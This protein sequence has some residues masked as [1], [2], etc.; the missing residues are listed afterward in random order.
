MKAI[1]TSIP[2]MMIKSTSIR[3]LTLE[4]ITV[5]LL[6]SA[7]IVVSINSIIQIE[8][9][10]A[11]WSFCVIP[12]LILSVFYSRPFS[13]NLEDKTKAI[14]ILVA[15]SL[16]VLFAVV[17][18]NALA[19]YPMIFLASISSLVLIEFKT[20]KFTLLAIGVLSIVLLGMLLNGNTEGNIFNSLMVVNL[21]ASLISTFGIVHYAIERWQMKTE[22]IND[23][24]KQQLSFVRFV[25]ESPLPLMRIDES[26]KILLMNSAAKDL[27]ANGEDNR[28]I[29]PPG[30]GESVIQAFMSNT[31]QELTTLVNG[32]TI[33]LKITPNREDKYVNLYGEDIT[34]I[35]KANEKF[36]ELNRAID[37]SADGVAVIDKDLNFDYI[38]KSFCSILGYNHP[39]ELLAKSWL[40]ILNEE[41]KEIFTDTIS[42]KLGLE[43]I[44]RGEAVCLL[45]GSG[46][47]DTYISLTKIPEGKIICYLKDNTEIKEYHNALIKAK[48]GAEAA[49]V[50]K[51]EFLSSMS[52]EIRTPLNG[53]LGMTTILE[54]T[55]LN[56]EQ[57]DYLTTIKHSGE[58]LLSIVNQVLDFSKIEAGDLE[59]EEE[60]VS[61]RKLIG[62]TMKL[63]THRASTRNNI[64]TSHIDHSVPPYVLGDYSR[65]S[66][67]LYNL[68][69][70]AIKFTD[71]GKVTIWVSAERTEIPKEIRLHFSIEDTGIGIKDEKVKELF[72]PFT[73]ADSSATREYGGTGLGLTIC[74]RLVT[75]MGGEINVKSEEG[76]GS[77]F[78][79]SF[80]TI[81]IEASDDD[82]A[83][84]DIMSQL[85]SGAASIHNMKILVAEDNYIN[86]KLIQKT[87]EKMGFSIDVVGTGLQALNACMDDD[88]DLVFMDVHMPEMDGIEATKNII[89]QMSNPPEI[90]ALTANVGSES[91]RE[92]LDA[93]MTDFLEKPLKLSELNRVIQNVKEKVNRES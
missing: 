83:Y 72:E 68:I 63:V 33:K 47:L 46:T 92:C 69:G 15:L 77:V 11:L 74:H 27:M 40:S 13:N 17:N 45:K 60:D 88:Y 85:N 18:H 59:L 66:Q 10:W 81:E 76:I 3:E 41:F 70:N 56:T 28:I 93:G 50:A 67:V 21:V 39:V 61:V 22:S 58:S 82:L 4:R 7:T 32:K 54:S 26:G 19:F 2:R 36:L 89:K 79:F 48:D 80:P 52:H 38:N 71:G 14:P 1:K 31:T 73:Q 62:E 25:N 91:K 86:Q 43:H 44:W 23:D 37:M 24:Y 49:T 64:I 53:V 35:E 65:I 8:G 6:H 30:C 20:L 57:R 42:P 5:L 16:A 34:E 87:F 90:V 55:A 9:N 51:S 12:V 29:Y 78:S 84:V 75:L